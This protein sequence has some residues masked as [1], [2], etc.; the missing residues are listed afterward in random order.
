MA[1]VRT[2]QRQVCFEEIVSK[3]PNPKTILSSANDAF[4]F[5]AEESHSQL[6]PRTSL[7]ARAFSPAAT[8]DLTDN[9]A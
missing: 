7:G 6:R 9:S 4:F 8:H 3:T 1:H 2:S 5:A